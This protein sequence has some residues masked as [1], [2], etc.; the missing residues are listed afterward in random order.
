MFLCGAGVSIPAGLP[1]FV[2]L[3][4]HVIDEVDPAQDS[5][6]RRAFGPWIDKD[7]TGAGDL[8][9]GL[10]QLF[11][12]LHREYR[13]E[14][15]ARIVWERLAKVEST[16]TREHDIVARISANG[17]G[18]P[19]I[20][21][22]NFDHLFESVL[23]KR[24]TPI[25]QPPMYPDLRHG[26]PAT[27]ITYL[28]GRLAG[29]ESDTHDYIL[30]SADL[31]RAYLAEGWATAFIQQLLQ[32]YT[33]VLLGY[34]AEDPPVQYLLQG[35]D[36][37]GRQTTDRLFAFGQGHRDEV[38]ATWRDRGVQAIP[39]GDSH[40]A[41]WETLEA[42]ADRADSPTAWRSAVAELSAKGP[43]ELAPHERGMV[44]HL[45]RTS[46]GAKQFADRKPAPPAEWLCV[47]DASCRYAEPSEQLRRRP[48][49][50]RSS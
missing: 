1:S 33:V 16:D 25:H 37:A 14:R 8:R 27:G 4:R 41:L 2:D 7:S 46:I 49:G 22:T 11:Q 43:R 6:I 38:E 44:A 28:H 23:A 26:V 5:E 18:R 29:A 35:L 47:F 30:S 19:Q 9:Q 17:E 45:V 13:R 15:I 48:G 21:T 32:R 36:S 3:T 39:Y 34:Q 20:V 40:E 12:L 50:V 10:D 42:W 24:A 31:G